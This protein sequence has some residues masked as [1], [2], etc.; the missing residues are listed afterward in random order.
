[1]GLYN[2][3]PVPFVCCLRAHSQDAGIMVTFSRVPVGYEF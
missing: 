1:M 3:A 2:D